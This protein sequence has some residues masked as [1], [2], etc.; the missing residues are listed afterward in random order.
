[1]GKGKI[2]YSE[3]KDKTC[4]HGYIHTFGSEKNCK[5]HHKA[6]VI[7]SPRTGLAF[8]IPKKKEGNNGKSI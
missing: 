7:I 3:I 2:M 6:T 8:K 1:L 4:R 5:G